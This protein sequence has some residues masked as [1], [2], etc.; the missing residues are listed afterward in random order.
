M[1]RAKKETKLRPIDG[2]LSTDELVKRLK[3]CRFAVLALR[4]SLTN[5]Q[6]LQ[7]H[8]R[9]LDQ[10]EDVEWLR[11]YANALVRPAIINSRNSSVKL[12]AACCLADVLRLFAPEA[13]YSMKDLAVRSWPLDGVVGAFDLVHCS[14]RLFCDCL[15]LS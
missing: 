2:N 14:F 3:V 6:A 8:I 9:S 4:L 15:C 1:P 11:S 5:A 12:L 7:L 13:P 10:Q